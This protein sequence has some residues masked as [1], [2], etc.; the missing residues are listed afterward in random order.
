LDGRS[1]QNPGGPF[2]VGHLAPQKEKTMF[3]ILHKRSDGTENIFKAVQVQFL[4]FTA[5]FGEAAGLHL[6]CGPGQA[7]GDPSVRYGRLLDGAVFVMNDKGATVAKY[8]LDVPHH[9]PPL[10][11]KCEAAQGES[12]VA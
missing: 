5:E 7:D 3:T 9:P 6:N 10:P 8:D 2:Y 4:P 1:E 12:L 11:D